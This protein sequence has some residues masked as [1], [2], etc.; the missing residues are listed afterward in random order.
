MKSGALKL[1]A[2]F[3]V[4]V[5]SEFSA[6]RIP[7]FV[8]HLAVVVKTNGIPFWGRSTHRHLGVS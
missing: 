2:Q 1:D 4:F 8:K 7:M 6:S 5:S 3:A